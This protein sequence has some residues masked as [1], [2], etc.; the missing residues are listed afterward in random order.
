MAM[1]AGLMEAEGAAPPTGC[2]SSD[3]DGDGDGE[4]DAESDR[5]GVGGGVEVVE[6]DPLGGCEVEGDA[7]GEPEADGTDDADGDACSTGGRAN[8]TLESTSTVV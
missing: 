2:C 3:C 1:V 4:L 5:D 8:S 7:L 6:D